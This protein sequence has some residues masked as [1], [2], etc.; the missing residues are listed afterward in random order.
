[1]FTIFILSDWAQHGSGVRIN[2]NSQSF[3]L[4]I[5]ITE[6]RHRTRHTDRINAHH[7][8]TRQR[9]E[10]FDRIEFNLVHGC[11]AHRGNSFSQQTRNGINNHSSYCGHAF[12]LCLVL[13]FSLDAA[14]AA[15]A[16]VCNWSVNKRHKN[17]ENHT[18]YWFLCVASR[19]WTERWL[20]PAFV[21]RTPAQNI[22]CNF[23]AGKR[24]IAVSNMDW[25]HGAK[26]HWIHFI[27]GSDGAHTQNTTAHC[28]V[29]LFVIFFICIAANA[30]NTLSLSLSLS[31]SRSLCSCWL[32]GHVSIHF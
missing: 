24:T 32:H 27:S 6:C 7:T 26:T 5:S 10:C 31:L 28:Y 3:N 17:R 30:T 29:C 23:F 22:F 16:H 2:G 12:L 25:P 18:Q 9:T 20:P 21:R 1:M 14:A 19:Q 8:R 4:S 11:L 15:V 13:E